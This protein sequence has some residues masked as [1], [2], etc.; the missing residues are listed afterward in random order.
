[1][2]H[3]E[4]ATTSIAA[5]TATVAAKKRMGTIVCYSVPVH[6]NRIEC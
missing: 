4:V 5:D 1:M 6:A 2:D 3:T